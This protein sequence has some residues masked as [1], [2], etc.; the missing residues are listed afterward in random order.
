MPAYAHRES[1]TRPRERTIAFAAV[2]LVQAAL[3]FVLLSGFRV[4]VRKTAEAAQRLI[5]ITLAKPPP[6]PPPAEMSRRSSEASLRRPRRSRTG[7]AVRRVRS[8]HMRRL[9]S[10]QLS[11]SSLP[12]RRQAEAVGR[13]QP[14][15][16]RRGR[17]RRQWL[18]RGRRGQ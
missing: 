7:L 5:D 6:V 10:H 15:G 8:P 17:H 2:A 14:P 12:H 4:D 1:I 16:R 3:A 9:P 13:G 11:L 18:W